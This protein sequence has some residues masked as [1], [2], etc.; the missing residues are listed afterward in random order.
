MVSDIANAVG[1]NCE[2]VSVMN[3]VVHGRLDRRHHP[4]LVFRHVLANVEGLMAEGIHELGLGLDRAFV[5]I[6][7]LIDLLLYSISQSGSLLRLLGKDLANAV[8][9]VHA[10]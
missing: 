4:P 8:G 1:R 3:A 2:D 10:P 7:D 6:L 5:N 9:G